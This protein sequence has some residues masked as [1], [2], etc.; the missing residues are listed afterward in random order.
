MLSVHAG[1]DPAVRGW[2]IS[3]MVKPKK[4][5]TLYGSHEPGCGLREAAGR[6][7]TL[8]SESGL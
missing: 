8:G 4:P 3:L 1:S 6:R 2:W 7:E 5:H